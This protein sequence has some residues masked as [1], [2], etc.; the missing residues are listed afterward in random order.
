M[1]KGRKIS[2]FVGVKLGTFASGEFGWIMVNFS[3]TWNQQQ[4]VEWGYESQQSGSAKE[5][6]KS[7]TSESN[8]LAEMPQPTRAAGDVNITLHHQPSST[9]QQN[10]K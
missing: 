2:Q 4:R 10:F 1:R 5:E 9:E 3:A 8:I 6:G 7:C